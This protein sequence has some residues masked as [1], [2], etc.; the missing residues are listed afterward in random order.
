MSFSLFPVGY[1]AP[2]PDSGVYIKLPED[3][4][5]K[6]IAFIG[7]ILP[8]YEYWNKDDKGI[9]MKEKPEATPADIRIDKTSRKPEKV[10]HFWACPVI[11]LDTRQ[12][13]VL[14]ISQQQIM[15]PVTSASDEVDFS[16]GDFGIKIDRKGSGKNNTKYT[17]MV[18]PIK[19][20]KRPTAEERQAAAEL[21]IEALIFGGD[22]PN[23]TADEGAARAADLM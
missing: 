2:E 11:D 9:R 3:G 8:G 1:E 14:Q 6:R 22:E 20:D 21:D 23:E 18:I 17:V 15:G 19:A 4:K 5:A 12:V 13:G 10:K 16:K 7:Q